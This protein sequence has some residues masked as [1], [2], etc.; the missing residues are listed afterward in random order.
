MDSTYTLSYFG[1]ETVVLAV[2]D[3]FDKHGLTE[4]VRDELMLMAVQRQDD[5]FQLVS[6][7]VEKTG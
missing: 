2:K 1:T 3:Y 6:D 7:F 5:F 4:D